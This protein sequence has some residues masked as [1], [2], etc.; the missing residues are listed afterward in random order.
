M[1]IGDSKNTPSNSNKT[2]HIGIGVKL[3]IK[4]LDALGLSK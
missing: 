4:L 2:Q 3:E 1:L